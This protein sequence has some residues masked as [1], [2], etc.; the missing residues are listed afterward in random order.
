MSAPPEY[1]QRLQVAPDALVPEPECGEDQE[2]TEDQA[3]D[4]AGAAD[5]LDDLLA[6]ERENPDAEL[7]QA[8]YAASFLLAESS[9]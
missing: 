1:Y 8:H 9:A 6:D 4:G 7:E 3:Q 5:D 2:G